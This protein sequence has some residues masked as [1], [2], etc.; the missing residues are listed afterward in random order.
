MGTLKKYVPFLTF[1]GVTTLCVG[2]LVYAYSNPSVDAE[3][4]SVSHYGGYGG[5]WNVRTKH[6]H[7]VDLY[8]ETVSIKTTLRNRVYDGATMLSSTT[9]NIDIPIEHDGSV[10]PGTA[11]LEVSFATYVTEWQMIHGNSYTSSRKTSGLIGSTSVDSG[12][13]SSSFTAP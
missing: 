1:I 4:D 3:F 8:N 7:S 11:E 12:W 9:L 2:F 5:G 10:P 13:K 6:K